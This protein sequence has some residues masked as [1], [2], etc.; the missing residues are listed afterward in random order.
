MSGAAR[1]AVVVRAAQPADLP[2]IWEL[3]RGLADYEKL[4]HEVTGTERQLGRD[5]FGPDPPLACV[6]AERGGALAGYALY[7][8]AYSSFITARTMWLE[9]LYVEP[10]ARGGGT[11]RALLARVAAIALERGC[12]RLGW[13]VLDWNRAAIGFYGRM[14]GTPAPGGLDRIRDEP[15]RDGRAGAVRLARVRRRS[16]PARRR[17]RGDPLPEPGGQRLAREPPRSRP[18]P[19]RP[20]RR[21]RPPGRERPAARW[22]RGVGNTGPLQHRE[23]R[24]ERRERRNPGRAVRGHRRLSR[25]AARGRR[26]RPPPT[27]G[28]RRGGRRDPGTP[29]P[30]PRDARRRRRGGR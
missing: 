9:D 27:R 29:H 19:S 6:V 21:P 30:P 1:D 26:R 25:S 22:R 16:A 2:R 10:G 18:R 13:L 8:P 15:R 12:A 28:G 20:S 3:L 23:A 5:L 7:F 17:H 4:T 11:G 24:P 14:G